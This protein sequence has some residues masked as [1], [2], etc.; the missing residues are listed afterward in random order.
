MS[1]GAEEDLREAKRY[2]EKHAPE[3]VSQW[4]ARMRRAVLSL[5]EMPQRCAFAPEKD[6]FG[7]E[8]RQLLEGSYRILFHVEG[9][10]VRVL[11]IRHSARQP[12]DVAEKE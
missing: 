9:K 12:V 6:L 7:L 5:R 10:S 3:Y 2:L 4:G 1:S 11:H 8:L